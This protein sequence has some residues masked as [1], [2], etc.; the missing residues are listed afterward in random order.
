MPKEAID[1]ILQFISGLIDRSSQID[2][3]QTLTKAINVKKEILRRI[4]RSQMRKKY[5]QNE[6][7]YMTDIIHLFIDS[8]LARTII[9]N[10]YLDN[11]NLKPRQKR[12]IIDL[13]QLAFKH[14]DL[15]SF[16]SQ[17]PGFY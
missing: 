9:E 10:N 3:N 12:K 8:D 11:V 17:K 14:L 2:S 7:L 6:H 4:D 16:P 1:D 15:T 13:A 5:D